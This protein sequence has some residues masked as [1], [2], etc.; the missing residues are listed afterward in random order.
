MRYL[1][2]KRKQHEKVGFP[3]I[4]VDAKQREFIGNFQNPERTY[5]RKPLHVLESNSP[6]DADGV[7]IPYGVYDT[8]HNEGFVVVETSHQTFE[9]AVACVRR[10]WR[11]EWQS[12]VD[13]EI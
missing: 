5:R 10:W 9:F 11:R 12:P 4:S 7:A 3:S 1:V 8:I 6:S 13:M 2:R